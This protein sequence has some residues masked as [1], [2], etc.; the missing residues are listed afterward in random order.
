MASAGPD[1]RRPRRGPQAEA[2]AEAADRAAARGRRGPAGRSADEE[3]ASL[4]RRWR[5]EGDASAREALVESNMP[6][7]RAVAAQLYARRP[8]DGVGFDEY[9]QLA[10]LGLVEA[11]DRYVPGRGAQFKTF[12]TPRVRGSVL[13]GLERLSER[14]QQRAFHRRSA[15]ERVASL[16]PEVLPLDSDVLLERLAE[17]SVGVALGLVLE[18]SALTLAA[19]ASWPGNAYQRL[20]LRQ[21]HDR[22]WGLV[23][24]LTPREREVVE[25]HYRRALPFEEVA[26]ALRVTKGRVSQLHRQAVERLRGLLREAEACDVAY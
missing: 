8:H 7:A 17:I 24:R 20:E 16:Q 22:L 1:P 3:E 10:L 6:F 12:A 26:R 25:L 13:S 14:E 9:Q 5:G 21:L 19:G 11:V 15:A 18:G 23:E 2:E 4:W